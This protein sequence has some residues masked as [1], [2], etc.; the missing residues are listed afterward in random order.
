MLRDPVRYS[1]V[2]EIIG[3]IRKVQLSEPG[4]G[5]PTNLCLK[6]HAVVGEVSGRRSLGRPS[7]R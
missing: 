2:L 1:P 5:E 4:S 3:D 6:D 7:S